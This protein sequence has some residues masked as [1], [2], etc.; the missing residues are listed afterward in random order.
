M[1]K[2]EKSPPPPSPPPPSSETPQTKP[3]SVKDSR[4][5]KRP[6]CC[7]CRKRLQTIFQVCI[8]EKVYCSICINTSVHKCPELENGKDEFGFD[9]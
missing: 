9:L 7:L 4:T 3:K 6:R 8:C 5:K 2:S 1:E